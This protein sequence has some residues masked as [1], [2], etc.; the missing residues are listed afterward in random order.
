MNPQLHA[1]LHAAWNLMA[2]DQGLAC[3]LDDAYRLKAHLRQPLS[4]MS[5][6]RDV[7]HIQPNQST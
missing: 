7:C 6:E 3:A 1:R 4:I 2:F 5:V